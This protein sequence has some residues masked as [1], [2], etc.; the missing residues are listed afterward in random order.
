MYRRILVPVDLAHADKLEKALK[1]AADLA[2]HYG[3]EAVYVGVTSSTPDQ[4]ARNPAEFETKLKA[5]ADD[6]AKRHGHK[7]SARAYVSHD[8]AIDLDSTLLAA[9]GE[10]SADLVVMASHVPT[11]ADYLWP[12][13]GGTVASHSTATVMIVR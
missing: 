12:S 13:N 3:I 11:V 6:Q 1:T 2:G 8:P 10:L 5:F 9:I 7:T 4:I